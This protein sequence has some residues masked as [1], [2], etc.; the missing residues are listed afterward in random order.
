MPTPY[1]RV[2][3]PSGAEDR[4]RC[5]PR[6]SE[7]PQNGPTPG[8]LRIQGERRDYLLFQRLAEARLDPQ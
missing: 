3:P 5:A 1:R 8:Y 2:G 4:L 6:L 7:P